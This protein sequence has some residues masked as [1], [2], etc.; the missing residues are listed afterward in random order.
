MNNKSPLTLL[1]DGLVLM[2][3]VTIYTGILVWSLFKKD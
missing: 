3:K 1:G 2:V